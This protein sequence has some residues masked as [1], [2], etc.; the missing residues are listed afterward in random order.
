VLPPGEKQQ[1]DI[2]FY[3]LPLQIDSAK[4]SCFLAIWP[5]VIKN[6]LGEHW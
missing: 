4:P 5:N 3:K 1:L 6:R 2:K